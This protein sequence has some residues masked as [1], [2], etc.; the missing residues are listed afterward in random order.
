MEEV[1]SSV[2][3]TTDHVEAIARVGAGETLEAVARDYGVSPHTVRR[4]CEKAGRLSGA[5]AVGSQVTCSVVRDDGVIYE[6][7]HDAAWD[8]YVTTDAL[9]YKGIVTSIVDAANGKAG[10]RAPYGHEWRWLDEVTQ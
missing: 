9:N 3:H 6:T 8:V 5:D 1:V 2:R 7:V 10:K 4:W